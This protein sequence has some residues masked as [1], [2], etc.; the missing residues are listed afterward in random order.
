MK[1]NTTPKNP[2]S[3]KPTKDR[4]L[5]PKQRAFVQELIDNPKQSATQA[6]LKTYGKPDKPISYQTARSVASQNLTKPNI[7]TKLAQYNDIVE[8]TLLQTIQDWG[9][10]D[11][12]RQREIAQNA[13]MYIHDKVHGKATQRVETRSEQVTISIDLTRGSEQP[14]Q[15]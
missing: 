5:T 7:K 4:P 3:G 8:S 6:V 9:Q 13:A 15:E 2:K 11:K 10:H 14:D 12:P 1:K